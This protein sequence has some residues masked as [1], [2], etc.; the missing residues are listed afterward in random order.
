MCHNIKMSI[1]RRGEEP[2]YSLSLIIYTR[3]NLTRVAWVL[4]ASR[5][6]YFT[7]ENFKKQTFWHL[8]PSRRFF[9]NLSLGGRLF[10]LLKTLYDQFFLMSSKTR[11]K[12]DFFFTASPGDH[13]LYHR[14]FSLSLFPYSN[15][16]TK[17]RF[18]YKKR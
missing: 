5:L 15:T 9:G 18:L 7:T 13:L 14:N 2:A 8:N 4:P 3:T 10:F 16:R 6:Q 17:F 12:T 11:P 1:Y